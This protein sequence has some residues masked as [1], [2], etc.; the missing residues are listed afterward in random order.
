MVIYAV[1]MPVCQ[2]LYQILCHLINV[3]PLCFKAGDLSNYHYT[4]DNPG[5][6]ACMVVDVGYSFSHIVPYIKG[7]KKREGIRRIDV[8]GKALTNYLKD[9]IS[10]R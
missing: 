4:N 1:F 8:G 9:I 6:L 2:C 7:K 3:C 5:T 10:Y